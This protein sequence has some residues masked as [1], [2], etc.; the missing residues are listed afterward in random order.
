MTLDE[1]ARLSKAAIN[2]A[3]SIA[4]PKAQDANQLEN[5]HE[6][7]RLLIHRIDALIEVAR[8]AEQYLNKSTQVWNSQNQEFLAVSKRVDADA[9]VAALEQ[10]K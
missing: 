10:L 2:K 9:L 1:L 5:L 7:L 6:S 8:A 3:W 4:A